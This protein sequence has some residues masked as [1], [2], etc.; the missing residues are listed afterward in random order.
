MLHGHKYFKTTCFLPCQMAAF[1]TSNCVK[2]H[3][4]LSDSNF[5]V[6]FVILK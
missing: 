1:H 5:V 6:G 4:N 3:K 2:L